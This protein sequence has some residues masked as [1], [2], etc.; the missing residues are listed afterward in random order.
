MART[1]GLAAPRD[2]ASSAGRVGPV[3]ARF[4]RRSPAA[5]AVPAGSTAQH[6]VAL[7]GLPER[8]ARRTARRH[9]RHGGWRAADAGLGAAPGRGGIP[10]GGE[11]HRVHRSTRV[12]SASSDSRWLLFAHGNQLWRADVNGGSPARGICAL[13]RLDDFGGTTVNADGVVL[14]G[15]VN[16]PINRVPLSGGTTGTRLGARRRPG[17]VRPG[18]PVVPARRQALSVRLPLGAFDGD[19]GD[20][21]VDFQRIELLSDVE[22]AA[23]V[24]P[25][26]IVFRRDSRVMAQRFDAARL[27]LEGVGAAR[28]TS[29][30]A[31]DLHRAS[32]TGTSC[33]ARSW[34]VPSAATEKSLLAYR[35]GVARPVGPRG[36]GAHSARRPLQP[37]GSPRTSAR[38]P[39]SSSTTR[40]RAISG[41][42]T[43]GASSA[44]V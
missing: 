33:T 9:D 31:R 25:G 43:S 5:L 10:E 1:R 34:P 22:N 38:S 42:L 26:L 29:A 15:Y 2:V 40:T 24:P 35:N 21:R 4:E 14:V 27:R 7:L 32:S 28:G 30:A 8:L 12:R 23:Y 13:P 39:S 11:G 16:G 17:R 36:G 41:R 19:G 3:A 37:S 20:A 44:R 6:R 18:A